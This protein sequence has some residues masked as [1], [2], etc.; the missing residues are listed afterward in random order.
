M[1]YCTKCGASM[2]DDANFCQ[3]CGTKC[4]DDET[5]QATRSKSS[6]CQCK[7]TRKRKTWLKIFLWIFF[8]PVMLIIKIVETPKLPAILKVI[9]TVL[10]FFCLGFVTLCFS[11]ILVANIPKTDIASSA[12]T[13]PASE[14]SQIKESSQN[15][16]F[17]DI[18]VDDSLRTDF[19]EACN[20][21]GVDPTHIK[22]LVQVDDWVGGP[23][24]SFSYEGLALRLYCNPDSTVNAIKLGVDIDV[25]KQGFEPFQI[26][27]YIPDL[28]LVTELQVLSKKYV[29]DQLNFPS[30]ADF[31]WL[32]WMSSRNHDLYTISS[33]VDAKNAFG[34]KETLPFTL[35]YQ[36]N[37]EEVE[38]V[39]FILNGKIILDNMQNIPIHD[40][41][42]IHI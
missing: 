40:L 36:I 13:V 12:H 15:N 32:D 38:L 27:D 4:I 17:K 19:I 30:T 42:L 3:I 31:A 33:S 11:I 16:L 29:L 5:F 14:T 34:V 10:V 28:T 23:R 37:K 21:I 24:Y 35:T 7:A 6:L 18:I 8:F 9:F 2:A 20:Q 41:S 22:D 1:K 25:Y 39:Q 26:S